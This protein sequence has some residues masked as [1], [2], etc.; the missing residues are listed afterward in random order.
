MKTK[1]LF[2][3][4]LFA[5]G[6]LASPAW[7]DGP[8]TASGDAK[9]SVLIMPLGDSITEGIFGGGYRAPLCASLT[10]AG[11]S[12]RFVGSQTVK[13]TPLLVD[14]GNEHH[15][16]HGGYALGHILLNLDG[17]TS[18]G[19]HWLDG[20]PGTRDAVYPDIILLMIATNDLGSHK[21]E[22]APTLEDYDKL[23][24]KLSAM[25]PKAL[26]IAAT[27]IPYTGSIEKYPLREQHQLEFNAA[28]PALVEKH[29]AAG[30]NIVL[31]DMRPTV[32]P[33][34]ISKDGVHPTQAGY[35]AIAAAWFSALEALPASVWEKR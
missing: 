3:L 25:R 23:I 29:R 34:H 1:S 22:V 24:D 13:S 4:A 31:K 5:C 14:S 8:A 6:L 19:G 10:K 9:N 28:L 21:R 15:E 2:G 20:I 7:A 27:L 33:E 11:R 12:F 26:I 18:N 30:Q 17:G 16:G 35:E 32:L